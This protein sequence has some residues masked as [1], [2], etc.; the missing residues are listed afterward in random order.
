MVEFIE[1]L[2]D[3]IDSAANAAFRL[4][5]SLARIDKAVSDVVHNESPKSVNSQQYAAW[6]AQN[7]L[8][9]DSQSIPTA[10]NRF[11]YQ[12]T[13]VT[14]LLPLS[15]EEFCLHTMYDESEY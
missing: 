10:S 12:E 3:C 8:G 11:Q 6:A 2:R 9:G 4:R 1:S 13:D 14:S 15:L 5:M 7:S